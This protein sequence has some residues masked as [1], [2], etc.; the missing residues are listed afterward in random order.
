MY[1]HKSVHPYRYMN[2]S[3]VTSLLTASEKTG[4]KGVISR[5]RAIFRRIAGLA[6]AEGQSRVS[7]QA[8]AELKV[9]GLS[10]GAPAEA[11]GLRIA[12]NEDRQSL[13]TDRLNRKRNEPTP[14]EYWFLSGWP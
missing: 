13:R 9:A 4:H 6:Q 1:F 10:K 5:A 12:A 8:V 7:D 3:M 2:L 11:G 14:L